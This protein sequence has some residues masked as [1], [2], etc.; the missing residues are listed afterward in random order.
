MRN[1]IVGGLLLSFAGLVLLAP[2]ARAQ[3]FTLTPEQMIK[4]TSKNPYD[5][6]PDGRPKV[7]DEVLKKLN[8]MSSEEVMIGRTGF[9]NQFVD[10]LQ[11]L[12]PGKKLIGRAFTLKLSPTRPD[13]A[14]IDAAEWKARG[15]TKPLNHQT[16]IDMLQPGDVLVV[17]ASGLKEPAG[18]VGDNLAFYIWKKTGAGFVIDGCI[19][20]I[21]G[22]SKFGIAGYYKYAVPGAIHNLMV[23]GINIPV[24]IGATTVFPGDVV[25]GDREGVNF[26]PPH[27]IQQ[28]IDSADIT[29]IHDEWTQMKFATGNYKSTDIYS[30]PSDPALIKEYEAYLKQKLSPTAYEQYMKR[31]R[32]GQPAPAGPR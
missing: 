32:P 27:L 22:I 2:A 5:R 14:D 1:R 18:I 16:A 28:Y 12:N 4:Y 3:V 8:D 7:P 11:V 25:F 23:T 17:D 29:H 10:S 24:Q 9:T 19:R 15:N 30:S 21:E 13:V 31:P 26:I 6:L 20:D